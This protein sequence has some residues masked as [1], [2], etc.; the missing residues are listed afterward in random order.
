MLWRLLPRPLLSWA[1]YD[2]ANTI[3]SAV[4][5]TAF[6]PLYFTRLA[7]SNTL[8]GAATTGSMLLAALVIPFL[9]ALSDQTG[10]TKTYLIR[11]TIV[12]IAALCCLSFFQNVALLL[13]FFVVACF[14]YHASLVFYNSLLPVVA[15]PEQQGF[16]SGLG[17]GLGYLGVVIA[18]PIA[19]TVSGRFGE[20]SVFVT[21]GILFLVSAQ[22]LFYFVPERRV[23]NPKKFTFSLWKAEW[24]KLVQLLL[25]I[26]SRPELMLFFSGNFLVVDA[27]N[28][29]ILWFS[30]YAREMFAPDQGELIAMLMGVN[31]SAFCMGL[32][33][34][35]LTDRWGAMKTLILATGVL[36][37][38][39]LVLT[40]APGFR[41]F[42]A[43]AVF[44]GAFSI[45]GIWTSG[46]KAL[47]DFAPRERIGEYFGVYGLITKV[48]VIGNLVFSIVADLAGFKMA[49]RVL[50]FPS[51]CGGLLLFFSM[52][53]GPRAKR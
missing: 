8:L 9:G 29:M 19:H 42:V 1:L 39:V 52:L 37:L 34:G 31:L 13:I 2:F 43:A 28:T 10:K 26:K 45:A 35:W 53:A 21:A 3:F 38:T 49:L 6:F 20:A 18:L 22:P 48:S 33:T 23:E 14:F 40:L 4:V 36:A 15:L 50:L 12:C 27:L 7:G 32:I 46:R 47:L 44:G 11:T 30:V 5:L 41:A 25:E 16:A 17:T 24:R 51:L